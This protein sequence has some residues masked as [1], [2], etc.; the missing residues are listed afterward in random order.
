M[1]HIVR[2]V[3][4]IAALSALMIGLSNNLVAAGAAA[5]VGLWTTIDDE[6]DA[7]RSIVEITEVNGELQGRVT[8]IFYRPDEKPDPVCDK[9]E[10]ARKDQ[11]VIGMTFLWGMKTDGD[12][13]AGGAIL[14][15]KNGK[16]YKAKM[17]LS[18]DG[19]R[20]RVRGFIGMPLLGRSQTW[21]RG[22]R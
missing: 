9:C 1:T 15:P 6:T 11:P 17:S 22:D 7:P 10:G 8:K 21:L 16:I 3:A 13:W 18:D 4:M 12:G 14:D 20:L 2:A 19:K 5:P